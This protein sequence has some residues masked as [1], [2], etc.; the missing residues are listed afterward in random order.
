LTATKGRSR[1]GAAIVDRAG[2]Q[3]LAR[4]ALAEDEQR[5]IGRRHL[6]ELADEGAHRRRGPD[7]AVV[8]RRGRRGGA[9]R[10]PR[11]PGRGVGDRADERV[12]LDRL[13]Q[14][15][16]GAGPHRRHHRVDL[17]V[18]GEHDD[19]Q[20]AV[21]LVQLADQLAAVDVGQAQV[22]AQDVGFGRGQGP[23]RA[24]AVAAHPH[25][26]PGALEDRR[27]QGRHPAVVLDQDDRAAGGVDASRGCH[28]SSLCPRPGPGHWARADPTVPRPPSPPAG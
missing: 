5:D 16:V 7:Q 8:P 6:L 14:V 27:D 2:D 21:A 20:V 3:L 12:A 9:A 15:V 25:R 19:R 17:I 10:R 1:A 23:P 28:P 13:D 18:G 22:E 26:I 4:P 11:A 24:R